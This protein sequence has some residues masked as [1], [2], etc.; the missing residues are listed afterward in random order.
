MIN[1]AYIKTRYPARNPMIMF[2][3]SISRLVCLLLSLATTNGM[4]TSKEDISSPLD[5]VKRELIYGG[6]TPAFNAYPWFA[7]AFN[8]TANPLRCGGSLVAQEYVLTAA[9]CVAG[10]PGGVQVPASFRIGAFSTSGSNGGQLTVTVAVDT[11]Y[12]FEGFDPVTFVNNIALVKLARRVTIASPVKMDSGS[13]VGSYSEGE[14][15]LRF[16]VDILF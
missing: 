7:E 1:A 11:L 6:I 4:D 12:I 3:R 15:I 10:L 14:S 8:A 5:T 9:T 13:V 2:L 16:E